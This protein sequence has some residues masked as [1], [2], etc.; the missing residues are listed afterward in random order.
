DRTMLDLAREI[1]IYQS[2][3]RTVVRGDPEAILFVEFSEDDSRENFRRLLRLTELIGDLGLSWDKT[4]PQWGGV[5]EVLDPK[6]QSAITEVRTG[7][8]NIMMSMKAE[9]KP[10]SFVE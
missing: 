6:L 1:A 5:V 3:I 10:V 9:G 2:T 8:L 7:G 4:G